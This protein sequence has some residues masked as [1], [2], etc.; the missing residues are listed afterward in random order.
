M[1]LFASAATSLLCIILSLRQLVLV[2]NASDGDP[3]TL[4]ALC[5]EQPGN[6]AAAL[7][8]LGPFERAL[9]SALVLPLAERAPQVQ[10][11]MLELELRLKRGTRTPAIAARI[12]SSVGFLCSTMFLRGALLDASETGDFGGIVLSGVGVV[13]AGLAGAWSCAAIHR[14]AQREM[15]VRIHGLS[16]LCDHLIETHCVQR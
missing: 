12:A 10:E 4:L 11:E 14:T 6:T 2:V 5:I 8:A 13:A 7:G 15:K 16:T 9:A 1:I 3:K